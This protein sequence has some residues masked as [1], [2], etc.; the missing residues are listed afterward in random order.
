MYVKSSGGRPIRITQLQQL[1]RFEQHLMN[2]ERSPPSESS[3]NYTIFLYYSLKKEFHSQNQNLL[4]YNFLQMVINGY[5][6]KFV[7]ASF[8]LH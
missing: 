7:V 5:Q 4:G 3:I 6:S 2:V 1:K 8:V